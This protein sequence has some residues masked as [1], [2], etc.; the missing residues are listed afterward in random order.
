MLKAALQAESP[1][2]KNAANEPAT[3]VTTKIAHASSATSST[4]PTAV[5]GF[6]SDEETVS[7]CTLA[8]KNASPNP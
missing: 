1:L 6:F 8:K 5:T 2:W 3:A 7:S 4:F